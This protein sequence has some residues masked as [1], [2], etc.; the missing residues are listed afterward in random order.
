ML[1]INLKKE[2]MQGSM[3]VK[4]AT[5]ITDSDSRVSLAPSASCLIPPHQQQPL[6]SARNC[7]PQPFTIRVNVGNV[8][9]RPEYHLQPSC[10]QFNDLKAVNL[11]KIMDASVE[12]K[13]SLLL[14]RYL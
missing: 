5:E 1:Q 4:S 13:R 12:L 2:G 11:K 10:S 14:Y 9:A 8:P 7:S 6:P 3:L